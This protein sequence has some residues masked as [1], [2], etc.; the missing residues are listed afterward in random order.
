MLTISN[1]W[2][3]LSHVK[4]LDH[5]SI[6]KKKLENLKIMVQAR[7][8]FG[9]F[10]STEESRTGTIQKWKESSI[11]QMENFLEMTLINAFSLRVKE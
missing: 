10:G 6:L 7:W 3:Q 5:H 9:K 2:L 1:F 8:E 4:S 11:W